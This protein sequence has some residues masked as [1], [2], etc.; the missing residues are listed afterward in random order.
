MPRQGEDKNC[1]RQAQA[2]GREDRVPGLERRYDQRDGKKR[3][4]ISLFKAHGS[5]L[6]KSL[7]HLSPQRQSIS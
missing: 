1:T 2:E 5:A 6:P 3:E 4:C 7:S